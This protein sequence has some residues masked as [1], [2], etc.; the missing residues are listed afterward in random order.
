MNE[1]GAPSLLCRW[2]SVSAK[3]LGEIDCGFLDIQQRLGRNPLG[4][5]HVVAFE[6]DVEVFQFVGFTR[7]RQVYYCFR[8][9][10]EGVV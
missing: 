8:L 9:A 6:L 1:R 7:F 10:A 5:H 2:R 3:I 4:E